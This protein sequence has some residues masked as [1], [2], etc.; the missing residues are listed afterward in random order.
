MVKIAP[1][2]LAANFACLEK[3]IRQILEPTPT[4]LHYDVMDGVFVPNISFGIPVLQSIKKA[5]P[6]AYYDVHL[7][8]I[9]PQKYIQ[10]F[11]DAGADSITIHVESQCDVRKTLQEIREKG[12]QCAISLRPSTPLEDIV[13]YLNQVDMVLVMSVEPGFG[14]QKFQPAALDK[15]RQ[16]KAYA[17]EK[18]LPYQIQIDGGINAETAPLCIQ[19]GADILVAGN[20][21]FGAP[22]PMQAICQMR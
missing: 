21:V 17:Q 22:D 12:A 4:M 20:A 14:G 15:V 5:V 6:Q 2:L 13:P 1:S 16:L 10:D 19:A 7:M 8:I 18:Q 3:E 9:N 11:I